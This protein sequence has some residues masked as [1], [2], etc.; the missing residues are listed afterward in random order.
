MAISVS[1]IRERAANRAE[2]GTLILLLAGVVVAVAIS[3]DGAV[4]RAING[5][6][7]ILWVGSAWILLT[8][9]RGDSKFW[10]RLA[11][12]TVMCLLLVIFLRPSDLA[13]AIAGFS[14]AG[15]IIGATAGARSFT[16]ATL[17]PALWLPVHLGTAVVKA[18]YRALADKEATLRSDPPPTA[19]LVPFAMIVAAM[20]GAWLVRS[21]ILPRIHQH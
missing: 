19:A 4:S 15:A 13:M 3:T 21:F 16:W 1:S 7:G 14:F 20:F 2:L 6:A 5:V 10:V 9:L 12:V 17:L 8:A 18:A 11:Q